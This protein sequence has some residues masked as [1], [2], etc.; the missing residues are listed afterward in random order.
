MY[1]SKAVRLLN[2]KGKLMSAP[3]FFKKE[4]KDDS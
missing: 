3:I 2:E 1:L 4:I